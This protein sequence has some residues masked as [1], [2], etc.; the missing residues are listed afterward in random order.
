MDRPICETIKHK[1]RRQ[2][3]CGQHSRLR[4]QHQPFVEPAKPKQRLPR[5]CD[6]CGIQIQEES[7][8]RFCSHRC[9]RAHTNREAKERRADRPARYCVRCGA[10]L[11]DKFRFGRHRK[12]CSRKCQSKWRCEQMPSRGHKGGALVTTVGADMWPHHAMLKFTAEGIKFVAN[13][14]LT[15][16]TYTEIAAAL[17]IDVTTFKRMLRKAQELAP[18]K[19]KHYEI[20]GQSPDGPRS[21][22]RRTCGH[23][24]IEFI[25][26]RGKNGFHQRRW[27]DKCVAEQRRPT[28]RQQTRKTIS[29][30]KLAEARAKARQHYAENAEAAREAYRKHYARNRE[31]EIEKT[32][33]NKAIK[34]H[35][36]EPNHWREQWEEVKKAKQEMRE[37]RLCIK[38]ARQ[39]MA[40]IR[41]Y[42]SQR[43]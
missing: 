30:E 35:G 5:Y 4:V 32:R 20:V 2:M 39:T 13:H 36:L 16:M 21:E 22:R 24:G 1:D 18:Y 38:E 3:L 29:P 8:R 25:E 27:C 19:Q 15:S 6:E 10:E 33:R 40:K 41:R 31:K 37:E 43:V 28:H 23:C 7:R 11:V 12:W 17:G 26:Y 9:Y 42:L 14:L 34:R